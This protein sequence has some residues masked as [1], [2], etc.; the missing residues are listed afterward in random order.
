M[1]VAYFIVLD[2]QEPGFDPFVNGKSLAHEARRINRLAKKLGLRELD[3][4]LGGVPEDF[5]DE[6]PELAEAETGWFDPGEGI[7]WTE[8]LIESLSADPSPLKDA[9]G[10]LDDLA[11][12]LQVLRQAKDVGARWQF[13]IDY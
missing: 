1:S 6:L 2:Q 9:D 3:D 4:F 11:E 13:Q 12:C 7:A 8:A 10:V 5:A